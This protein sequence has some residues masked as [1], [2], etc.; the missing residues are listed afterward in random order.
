MEE[1]SK[2]SKVRKQ[3]LSFSIDRHS[4]DSHIDEAT[5]IEILTTNNYIK[6]YCFFL[7][8]A[9]PSALAYI[10]ENCSEFINLLFLGMENNEMLIGACGLGNCWVLIMVISVP[11][12][13][14][15]AV[16][17]SCSQ[18]FGVRNYRSLGNFFNR[19]ILIVSIT[20]IP[21]LVI[22]WN[23]ERI[24]ILLGYEQL[25]AKSMGEYIRY[26]IPSMILKVQ[27]LLIIRFLQSQRV[28]HVQFYFSLLAAG[29]HTVVCYVFVHVLRFG[30]KGASIALNITSLIRFIAFYSY[31]K[32]SDRFV[33]S[34]IHFDAQ[35]FVKW[36]DFL[37]IAIPNTLMIMPDYFGLFILSFEAG[38][39]S[40]TE[41]AS[42]SIMAN[43]LKF[44]YGIAY[45][46]GTCS[47]TLAGN[48]LS[49]M[50]ADLIARVPLLGLKYY[51]L[52]YAIVLIP[53]LLFKKQIIH[54][55]SSEESIV[56]L[57]SSLILLLYATQLTDGFQVIQNNVLQSVGKT[58]M[59]AIGNAIAF[60]II[61]HP[62]AIFLTFHTK[63]RVFGLWVGWFVATGCAGVFYLIV[64]CTL[65][66][67][68]ITIEIKE[69][70]QEEILNTLTH[71]L[72][73]K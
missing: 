73:T 56:K 47:G 31:V 66:L 25:L 54:L 22:S 9:I 10:V 21:L 16:Y 5:T 46:I 51:Y 58:V 43:L 50:H 41:L 8:M 28:Y 57:C 60:I 18:A 26:Q 14:G 61:L 34:W 42:H 1:I 3:H 20:L 15:N 70:N 36:K 55:F 67:K 32:F 53:L 44:I 12:G 29:T 62:V 39:L 6:Q 7:R 48:S 65:D 27:V 38:Y 72:E 17:T 13:L 45:G 2:S 68:S 33:L 23:V 4:I 59:V 11:T 64:W 19:A 24:F 52:S 69:K 49:E 37:K 35:S 63:L 40:K 30:L 71:E